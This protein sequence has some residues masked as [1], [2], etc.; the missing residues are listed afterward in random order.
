MKTFKRGKATGG[1]IIFNE[2]DPQDIPRPPSPPRCGHAEGL[3][4]NCGYV[5]AVDRFIPAAERMA[6][7]RLADYIEEHGPMNRLER[8][9]IWTGLFIEEMQSECEVAG[10]RRAGPR[11][12]EVEDRTL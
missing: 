6:D 8:D 10:L 7:I 9:R 4:H 1:R 3:R 5:E 12:F 2:V 11:A